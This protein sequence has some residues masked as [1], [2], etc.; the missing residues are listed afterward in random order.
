MS[1]WVYTIVRDEALMIKYWLRHYK[2]FCDRIIVYDEDSEDGTQ[3][4]V[5]AEGSELRRYPGNGYMDDL[6][7]AS[8]ASQ[9]YKEARGSADW[10]IWVDADEFIYHENIRNHLDELKDSRVIIPRVIGYNMFSDSP[11]RGSG[12]IYEEIRHG[13]PSDAYSKIAVVNPN[14]ELVWGTGKHFAHSEFGSHTQLYDYPIN[15]PEPL[16]LL[17]YRWLGEQWH[18][19]RNARNY[20][21]LNDENKS[22]LHGMEV[23]PEHD[24]MMYSPSWYRKKY[25]EAVKVI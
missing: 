25:A 20:G 23:Y 22:R 10:V 17:H 19:R 11:P 1:I 8:F 7:M 18:L 13:I 4:I 15:G 2:T 5:L 14:I 3:D 24:G 9:Q 12:Q 6:L 16:K 21:R